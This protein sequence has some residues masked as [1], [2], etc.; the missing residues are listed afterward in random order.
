MGVKRWVESRVPLKPIR[1][2]PRTPEKPV[3]KCHVQTPF[4]EVEPLEALS[5][6]MVHFISIEVGVALNNL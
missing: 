3:I 5:H 4:L 2:G 6:P 1:K